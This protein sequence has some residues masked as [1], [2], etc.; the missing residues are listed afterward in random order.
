MAQQ[1]GGGGQARA[2]RGLDLNSASEEELAQAKQIGPERA[3][4]IV[5]SRPFESWDDLKEVPGFN[6]RLIQDLQ[7]AGFRVEAEE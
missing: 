6:D 2:Q 5:E 4:A 1:S 3:R 7:G